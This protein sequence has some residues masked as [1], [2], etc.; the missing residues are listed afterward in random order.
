[1]SEEKITK[2]VEKSSYE[3]SITVDCAVFGFQD[4]MLK[5]LLVKRTIDP[6]KDFWL[7]PGG[8]INENRTVEQAIDNVLFQLTGIN[9][10]HHQQIKCY[11]DINRHPTKRVI[12]I[13]FLCSGKT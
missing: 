11:S 5:L 7:L 10:I 2:T 1:M 4:N 9:N 13:S 6:F 12:T 3:C 8:I